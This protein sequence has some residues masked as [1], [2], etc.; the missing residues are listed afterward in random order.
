MPSTIVI[1]ISLCIMLL[2]VARLI[3]SALRQ[4]RLMRKQVTQTH[5]PAHPLR[6]PHR[7]RLC[8]RGF[9]EFDPGREPAWIFP[10]DQCTNRFS[11]RS[12]HRQPASGTPR[13]GSA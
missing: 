13:L 8:R 9:A 6:I 11:S 1:A 7:G 2:V 5:L 4:H 10:D 12:A 3:L